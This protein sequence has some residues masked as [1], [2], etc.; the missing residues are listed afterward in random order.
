ME[1]QLCRR[2]CRVRGPAGPLA[3]RLEQGTHNPL[4]VGS[5]PTGPSSASSIGPRS[6]LAAVRG[7]G[8]ALLLSLR[9]RLLFLAFCLGGIV[10]IGLQLLHRLVAGSGDIGGDAGLGT[11][12]FE[13]VR[14]I[15]RRLARSVNR[16]AL[17]VHVVLE[18]AGMAPAVSARAKPPRGASRSTV[19]MAKACFMRSVLFRGFVLPRSAR[20]RRRPASRGRRKNRRRPL[21]DRVRESS[22]SHFRFGFRSFF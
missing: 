15:T 22:R 21:V 8:C 13:G 16:D 5:N 1:N 18:T 17:V 10:Q 14:M 19:P 6:L 9:L 7:H 2:Y 11:A 20:G 12:E 4:V 3:Q